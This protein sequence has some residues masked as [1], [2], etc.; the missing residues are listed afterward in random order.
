[1]RAGRLQILFQC[2]PSLSH[3]RF[4]YQ[5]CQARALTQGGQVRTL[6]F[7]NDTPLLSSE[8]CAA[9][10]LTEVVKDSVF[11]CAGQALCFVCVVSGISTPI[12]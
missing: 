7:N 10:T 6:E 1:M 3:C 12:L 2:L 11:L 4:T 5:L 9:L 8:A